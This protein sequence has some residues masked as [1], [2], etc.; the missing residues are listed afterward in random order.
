[1]M[2]FNLAAAT[3][4]QQALDF[5]GNLGRIKSAISSA[6]KMHAHLLVLP[7]LC[8]PGYGCEDYFHRPW[9]YERCGDALRKIMDAVSSV[10][11][12]GQMTVVVGCP[13][14]YKGAAYNA[15]AV[16]DG[17]AVFI[18]PKQHLAGETT[19]YEPRWFRSW[20][21]GQTA[22]IDVPSVGRVSA[23][24]SIV[25][26][27]DTAI[28]VE[29]CEDAWVSDRPAER[30]ASQ[31]ADVIVNC[32]ASHFSIGKFDVRRRMIA[33]SSRAFGCAYAYANLT[34]MDSGRLVYDGGCMIADGGKII[35]TG[36]RLSFDD[37]VITAAPVDLNAI[38]T[39]RLRRPSFVPSRNGESSCEIGRRFNSIMEPAGD[40]PEELTWQEEVERA[41]ALGLF[42]YMRRS[43][44][45]GCVVS[46]SGGADSSLCVAIIDRMRALSSKHARKLD[47]WPEYVEA[48]DSERRKM[49]LHGVYQR[50]CGSTGE[51]EASAAALAEQVGCTFN[52]VQVQGI[53]DSVTEASRGI[54][55]ELTFPT[56]DIPLQNLTARARAP[57]PWVLANLHNALLITT[58]NRSEAAVGYSTM[59][60]DT[61][62][63]LGLINGLSKC[64]VLQMLQWFRT[65]RG[66]EGLDICLSL[67]PSAELRPTV[68]GQQMQADE[69]DLMP[70][71]V[72]EALERAF[73]IDGLP[74]EDLPRVAAKAGSPSPEAHAQKFVRLFAISQW[75]RERYA[76][77]IHFDDDNL[78][79]RSWFRGPIVGGIPGGKA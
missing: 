55:G 18:V 35:A 57:L 9:L 68:D 75:K 46:M 52:S 49:I 78:D 41:A 30:Y 32:S 71:G 54:T 64:S 50:A 13:V 37:V 19:Y 76:P 6:A 59:D 63:G 15:A 39:R 23:G 53:I 14:V 40:V 31:G 11:P 28:G 17:N 42:D 36:P 5:D 47:Y 48:S 73:I 16:T 43:R 65:E 27:G 62:G 34:G 21:A 10:A 58:S 29:V 74:P 51:T 69:D 79:S 72:L 22:I 24:Q 33:E 60:G 67:R 70:F 56:H 77:G 61:A 44:S 2:R 66:M 12:G 38:R 8:I 25:W 45:K 26:V 20:P 1:M 3:L 7:E 4:N